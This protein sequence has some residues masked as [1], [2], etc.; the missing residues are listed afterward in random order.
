MTENKM[1]SW[2]MEDLIALTDEVQTAELDYKGKTVNIQWC[3]LIESEEPK[4]AIPSEDTSED[5]KTE[6]YTELASLKIQKMIQKA[7]EKNPEGVFLTSDVWAQ[8]PPTLKY[9]VS[10]K[11]LGTESD[12]NF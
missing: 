11:I 1:E 2:S 5:D 12:V 9:R 4:M 7:N 6:Y 3:E 8:L 10:A